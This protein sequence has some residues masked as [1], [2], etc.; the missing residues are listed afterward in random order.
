M[1]KR[2]SIVGFLVFSLILAGPFARS[3]QNR[4]AD[5]V[6]G[7]ESELSAKTSSHRPTPIRNVIL[8]SLDT[9]R[10]D[11]ISAYGA[12]LVN[13][14]NIGA[15]AEESVVFENAYSPIP[16]TLPAH[17]TM[18]TGKNPL[19]HGVFD[20]GLYQLAG[21]HVT[22]AEILK[23]NGY[24]TAAFVSALVM[25]SRY[26]LDQGFE[27]YDDDISDSAVIGE[28][29]GDE[30]TAK[31]VEWMR[32]HRKEKKF[33]FLHLFDPHAPYEAPEPFS[34]KMRKLYENY[35]EY[36]RDY[37]AEIAFVDHC[38]GYFIRELKALDLYNESLIV[39]TADH[40]ESHGEHGENTHGFFIYTSTT[41]VPLIVR[42]PD[43]KSPLR[44]SESVGIVDIT[45]TI[46]SLLNIDIP[47]EFNGKELRGYIEGK[48]D[49]FP[50]R[51]FFSMSIEP[52]KYGGNNLYGLIQNGYKYIH[53]TESELYDMTHDVYEK[54]NIIG[55][56][57]RRAV[58]LRERLE[59]ILGESS[60]I[61]DRQGRSVDSGTRK[62]LEALGYVTTPTDDAVSEIDPKALIE[63]HKKNLI[64]LSHV[65][66][67][68]HSLALGAC[69]E[70]IS[71]R[72]DFHLG[73]LMMGRVLTAS[74]RSQDAIPFFE[75]ATELGAP[76]LD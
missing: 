47:S 73:Y 55:M 75:K 2:F 51:F 36:I 50:D 62:R 66:P 56:Q 63:Y 39:V 70:M 49:Q 28:R 20:N 33:I 26:G 15:L 60:R 35:P 11:A 72:P 31:A 25:D 8:I 67:E 48:A 46:Y 9:V 43:L 3:Q 5:Q 57:G 4:I 6:D 54:N 61:T 17:A 27:V 68:N 59:S 32:S 12:P 42:V 40:G 14:P 30:T 65:A 76:G 37:V 44:V 64:A 13:S 19:D 45:P 21:H 71:M 58:K 34:S 7:P 29:S 22:L 69:E 1:T 38:V 53:S 41:K 23:K 74:G 24:R 18:F 10:W 52:S 16:V